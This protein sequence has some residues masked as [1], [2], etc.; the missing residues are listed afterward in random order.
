M[1]ASSVLCHF[2][3]QLDIY[4]IWYVYK[5][6]IVA[7]TNCCRLSDVKQQ[8]F[9]FSLSYSSGSQS[10]LPV[11]KNQSVGRT[12]SFW[13]LLRGRICILAF[14]NSW[15][16]PGWILWLVASY[17]IFEVHHSDLLP[18]KHD[19]FLFYNQFSLHFPLMETFCITLGP[20]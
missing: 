3:N 6:P 7:I 20:T 1:R 13:S 11:G 15:L 2:L 18:S 9:S 10:P 19:L 12:T 4:N 16:L 5:F 8:F 17:F 14:L